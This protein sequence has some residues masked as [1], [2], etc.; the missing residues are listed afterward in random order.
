MQHALICQLLLNSNVQCFARLLLPNGKREGSEWRVGSIAGE[1]GKSLGV[2]SLLRKLAS[3][4][5]D[6][7]DYA[8]LMQLDQVKPRSGFSGF[9]DIIKNTLTN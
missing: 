3:L 6:E 2:Y 1:Q 9:R 7:L 4:E 5:L 8:E